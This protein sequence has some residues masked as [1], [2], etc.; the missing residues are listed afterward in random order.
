MTEYHYRRERFMD[1][2]ATC[3]DRLKHEM[4]IRQEDHVMYYRVICGKKGMCKI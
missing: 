4:Y 2:C 3:S 1:H